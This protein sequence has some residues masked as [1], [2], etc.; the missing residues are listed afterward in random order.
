MVLK[1]L[2]TEI[3][4]YGHEETKTEKSISISPFLWAHQDN[5]LLIVYL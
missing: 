2:Q 4:A 3:K 1:T 5:T